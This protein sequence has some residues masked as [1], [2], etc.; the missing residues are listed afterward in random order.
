MLGLFKKRA[1]QAKAYEPDIYRIVKFLMRCDQTKEKAV[2][3]EKDFRCVFNL[4]H[5]SSRTYLGVP[6]EIELSIFDPDGSEW[7]PE[8][9][10]VLV[11]RHPVI[12]E[13]SLAYY[14]KE[15]LWARDEGC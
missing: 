13:G 4:F 12:R 15:F 8:I 9:K 14:P 10:K 3:S 2:L 11:R 5:S 1:D 7:P 6:C